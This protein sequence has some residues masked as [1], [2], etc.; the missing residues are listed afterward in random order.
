MNRI[1][2]I[3]LTDNPMHTK[4]NFD[5]YKKQLH[6]LDNLDLY[7]A[8][9]SRESKE[10]E[11]V[12]EGV[13]QYLFSERDALNL[14]FE[15]KER[16]DKNGRLIFIPGNSD[17]NHILFYKYQ[18]NYEYYYFVEDDVVYTGDM[19]ILVQELSSKV[20]DLLCT[21]VTRFFDKWI[22]N[23]MF[24]PGELSRKKP[25]RT[26]FIPFARVSKRGLEAIIQGYKKGVSGHSE[27]TWPFALDNLGCSIRDIGG[28]GEFVTEEYKNKYYQ[29]TTIRGMQSGTFKC[30]PARFKPGPI[31]N[32]LYHPVK[33]FK[34]TVK[35]KFRRMKSILNYYFSRIKGVEAAR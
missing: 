29:G 35:T 13:K 5:R 19:A 17:Y 12:F 16:F 18:P 33:P 23:D 15:S 1:A 31:K 25:E 26:C 2:F 4:G 20:D 6:K 28:S 8:G 34:H 21:H 11:R 14:N 7:V 3:Y 32:C 30:N 22:Y 9:Y 27:M 10:R 24:D